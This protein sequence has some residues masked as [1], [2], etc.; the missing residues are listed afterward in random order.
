MLCV[1]QNTPPVLQRNAVQ[2]KGPVLGVEVLKVP[3]QP[4]I[5][6]IGGHCSSILATAAYVVRLCCAAPPAD[7]PQPPRGPGGRHLK[8]QRCCPVMPVV[9]N[10][11]PPRGVGPGAWAEAP[12]ECRSAKQA[13]PQGTLRE[14]CL[15]RCGCG[16]GVAVPQ[17]RLG[18]GR[19]AACVRFP[20]ALLEW[21]QYTHPRCHVGCCVIIMDANDPDPSK[22][23]V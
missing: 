5:R 14:Q 7:S 4:V 11:G 17:Q 10:T 1:H 21:G 16:G 20:Q 2:P 9:H 13:S 3:A 22:P 12:L 19:A 23:L 6:Q 15:G 18:G 8:T